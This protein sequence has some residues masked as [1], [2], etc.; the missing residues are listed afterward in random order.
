MPT[1]LLTFGAALFLAL[2]AAGQPQAPAKAEPWEYSTSIG[3]LMLWI[4]D[5]TFPATGC[6]DVVIDAFITTENLDTEWDLSL[7]A[8]SPGPEERKS[9]AFLYGSGSSDEQDSFLICPIMGTGTYTVTGTLYMDDYS[10]RTYTTIPIEADFDVRKSL[11]KTS[12]SAPRMSTK[13]VLVSGR[14][15]APSE[16]GSWAG[17]RGWVTIEA[18]PPQGT[19]WVQITR[20][21]SSE[22]DGFT[23]TAQHRLPMNSEFR[24]VFEGSDSADGSSS[25]VRR[26]DVC[27]TYREYKQAKFGMTVQQVR[28]VFGTNGQQTSKSSNSGITVEI[29]SYSGCRD[30]SAVSVVFTNGRL[31]TKSQAGL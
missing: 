1:K 19:R 27:I 7:T 28:R 17:T 29:R 2:G 10:S 23:T 6:V 13:T 26:G 14:V 20:V 31:E 24:A 3:S 16:N 18:R 30:F 12:I 5:G 25:A 15:E 8:R 9:S 21:Y 11:S 4:S 22:E